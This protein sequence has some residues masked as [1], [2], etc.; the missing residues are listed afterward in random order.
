MAW[1]TAISDLRSLLS[2]NSADRYFYRKKV[3]GNID[4]INTSFKTFE[5]RRV[6]DFTD[7]VSSA[8]PLGVYI[9]GVRVDP[10]TVASD[11]LSTG[12]FSLTNAPTVDPN[13]GTVLE[14]TYYTQQFTDAELSGFLSNVNNSLQYGS[15]F[16]QLDPSL[17]E[18]SLHLSAGD[19]LRKI[20]M[21]WS[22][23]SS[24][25]F[26][27]ED[28]P[29]KQSLGAA[30]SYFKMAQLFSS[31]GAKLRDDRYTRAGQA[32]APNF[33]NSFGRVRAVTPRR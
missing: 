22:M 29:K 2:D 13:L 3:F 7:A 20:A 25:T 16:T 33:V 18:A 21:R 10:A 24:E 30:D 8:A 17:W 6:T 23:R 1:T 14:A 5:F 9:N 15:D 4:G 32:L 27:L 19:A 28:E 12:E 26:L 11:N 31:T